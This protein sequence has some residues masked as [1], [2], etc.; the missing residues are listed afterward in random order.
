MYS[1]YAFG[2][3]GF[4]HFYGTKK[5]FIHAEGV[6]AVF[7]YQIIGINSVVFGF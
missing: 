4:A 5:H 6:G 7:G 2:I 1:F 3:P